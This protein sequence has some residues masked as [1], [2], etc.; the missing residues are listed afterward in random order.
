M[1]TDLAGPFSVALLGSALL[2]THPPSAISMERYLQDA[3]QWEA[4]GEAFICDLVPLAACHPR[5]AAGVRR[6]D[7]G[8][9]VETYQASAILRQ[10]CREHLGAE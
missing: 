7:R 3:R 5:A 6:A 4:E 10:L 8:E 9:P 2:A 1:R